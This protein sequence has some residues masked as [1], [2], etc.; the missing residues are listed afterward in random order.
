[1]KKRWSGWTI[2]EDVH[3]HLLQPEI[4]HEQVFIV[5]VGSNVKNQWIVNKCKLRFFKWKGV[6][7]MIEKIPISFNTNKPI[8]CIPGNALGT[9]QITLSE[10]LLIPNQKPD[11]EQANQVFLQPEVTNVRVV[12]IKDCRCDNLKLKV[13]VEGIIHEKIIYTAGKP[14]Q[15]VH[16]AEFKNP[17]YAAVL[18]D[19]DIKFKEHRCCPTVFTGL[20]DLLNV[21]VCVEDVSISKKTSRKLIKHSTL[22]I[23]VTGDIDEIIESI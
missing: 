1:M 7:L 16:S 10:E 23:I 11:V 18:L 6:M 3:F 4:N 20:A 13:I 12:E 14:C 22:L 15:P 2:V 21:S 5:Q 19:L 17:F 9:K 8:C